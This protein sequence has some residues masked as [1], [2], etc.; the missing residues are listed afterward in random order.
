MESLR[1]WLVFV[2][3]WCAG[4]SS[5]NSLE[6]Y[7]LSGQKMVVPKGPVAI[8]IFAPDCPWAQRYAAEFQRLQ[9]QDSFKTIQFVAL[10]PG[11]SYTSEEVMEFRQVTGYTAPI[12]RDTD[13]KTMRWLKAEISPQFFLLDDQK[14][15][16]YDGAFDN[17]LRDLGQHRIKADSAYFALA[18]TALLQHQPIKPKKTKAIGCY[19][20]S[21]TE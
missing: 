5:N 3:L 21:N 20:E 8:M 17:R 10:I 12:Y 19:L 13:E 7:D 1:L 15:I 11:K 6:W 4:C 18:L 16:R 14:K 2:C 9:Q